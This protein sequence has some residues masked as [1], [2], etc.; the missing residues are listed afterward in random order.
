MLREASQ[1]PAEAAGNEAF[2]RAGMNA[3]AGPLQPA[4]VSKELSSACAG[5]GVY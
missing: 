1:G 3:E 2:E 4:D 5:C